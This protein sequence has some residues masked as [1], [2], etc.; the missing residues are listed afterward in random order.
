[1]RAFILAIPSLLL[2][3]GA[4]GQVASAQ[5][6]TIWIEAEKPSSASVK[7]DVGAPGRAELLS[8]G[9][10][11]TITGQIPAEG[12]TVAYTFSS[13]AGT[14]EVWHRVGFEA[15]R[16][17]FEW[18]IDQGNWKLVDSK[19]HTID[20]QELADWNGVA[21]MDMGSADLAAGEHKLEIHIPHPA[22]G[23]VLYG[24]D[25]FALVKGQFHPDGKW[26]PGEDAR[27]DRD[28]AAEKRTFAVNSHIGAYRLTLKL[29]GD[30]EI[31]RDD[32]VS[33][34]LV[35]TPM[36]PIDRFPATRRKCARTWLWP[37]VFG[38][39]PGLSFPPMQRIAPS[40]SPF[41]RTA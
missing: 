22:K 18:R 34:A 37:T 17:P 6:G 41:A 3:F 35:A 36:K 29:D 15:A 10:W 23:D 24:S 30:W 40:C 32:E 1:M 25:A 5:S 4:S 9:K 39:G 27:T 11:M 13:D 8:G 31:A 12:A 19:T 2:A 38:I 20:L 28:R 7:F 14:R 21:W 33:P 26:K 16:S